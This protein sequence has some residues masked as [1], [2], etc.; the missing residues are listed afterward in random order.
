MSSSEH[1]RIAGIR[2]ALA[3]VAFFCGWL[4]AP[5]GLAGYAP[6]VCSMECCVAGGHCCCT[7]RHAMVAGQVP[8]GGPAF[9]STR[10]GSACPGKCLTPQ[11]SAQVF[12]RHGERPGAAGFEPEASLADVTSDVPPIRG[13]DRCARSSPRA[14]PSLFIRQAA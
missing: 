7:P 12:K 8:D 5:V 1:R 10:L 6:D 11:S 9:A 14:P 2:A 4:A 3:L 13:P